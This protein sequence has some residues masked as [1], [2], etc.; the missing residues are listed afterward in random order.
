MSDPGSGPC[1]HLRPAS[2]IPVVGLCALLWLIT[3][4]L[5][6]PGHYSV[7]SLVQ[8]AEGMTGFYVSF[9]PPGM[10]ILLAQVS[11]WG[12]HGPFMALSAV[13]YFAALALLMLRGWPGL[14]RGWSVLLL[15]ICIALGPVTLIY[16]GTVWKD[17]F[18]ANLLLLAFALV[19]VPGAPRPWPAIGA[20]LLLAGLA[21]RVREHGALASVVLIAYAAWSLHPGAG[22]RADRGRVSLRL[23]ALWL[24]LTLALGGLITSQQIESPAGGKGW[25]IAL[26]F[27]IAGMVFHSRHPEAVLTRFGIDAD[28]AVKAV[29]EAYTPQRVDTLRAF[30]ATL[31]REKPDLL[32]LWW[33]LLRD[34]PSSLW[35]HKSAAAAA[36]LGNRTDGGC[37]PAHVGVSGEVLDI[38]RRTMPYE[39]PPGFLPAPS[40]HTQQLYHYRQWGLAAFSGWPYILLLLATLALGLHR[41]DALATSLAL[42]GLLYVGSFIVAG[43][44]CDFRYLY[45]GVAA[46]MLAGLVL[47]QRTPTPAICEP[48][49]HTGS[50]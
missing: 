36:L 28:A 16:N 48:G 47:W 23:G 14:R 50:R 41:R 43:M 40:P 30:N 39:F 22:H 17:V 4:R 3:V 5:N 24:G 13:L 6:W 12:G 38:L 21:T 37:L 42:A 27:E 9:N 26:R 1:R 32:R 15:A 11:R 29:R 20:A 8:L 33:A 31:S 35:R 7:D 45:F 46:S 10:S 44:A 2:I 34:E 18:C 49:R 25:R 19:P